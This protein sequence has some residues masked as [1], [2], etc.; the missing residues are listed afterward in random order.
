MGAAEGLIV[1]SQLYASHPPRPLSSGT[2]AS[3]NGYCTLDMSVATCVR[4]VSDFACASGTFYLRALGGMRTHA[5]AYVRVMGRVGEHQT[6]P[7]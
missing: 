6:R 7:T 4:A 1:S 3:R 5:W 2:C